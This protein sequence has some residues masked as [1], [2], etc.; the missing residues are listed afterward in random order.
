[1][2]CYWK[3]LVNSLLFQNGIIA[4]IF[5]IKSKTFFGLVQRFSIGFMSILIFQGF[6][7]LQCALSGTHKLM[8]IIKITSQHSFMSL[9]LSKTYIHIYQKLSRIFA[10]IFPF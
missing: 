10:I 4:L 5:N 2:R 6:K 3:R 1:M 7:A 8:D 9:S